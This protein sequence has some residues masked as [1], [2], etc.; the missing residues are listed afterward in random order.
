MKPVALNSLEEKVY[1]GSVT[2]DW[3]NAFL[4][5]AVTGQEVAIAPLS[6]NKLSELNAGRVGI[7]LLFAK[8]GADSIAANL[9]VYVSDS[10]YH[11]SSQGQPSF[12]NFTGLFLFFDLAQNFKHGVRVINGVPMGKVASVSS[13]AYQGG[14]DRDEGNCRTHFASM[15]NDCI[16]GF[17]DCRLTS[18]PMTIMAYEECG[19]GGFGG[20][21]GGGSSTTGSTSGGTGNGGTPTFFIPDPNLPSFLHAFYWIPLNLWSAQNVVMPPGYD[22]GLVEK[23]QKI[24]EAN[25]GLYPPQFE[26][27]MGH[28]DAVLPFYNF[29]YA[30]GISN[31]EGTLFGEMMNLAVKLRL[32]SAQ[33]AWF[34]SHTSEMAAATSFAAAH[35]YDASASVAV[36][37]LTDLKIA[38]AFPINV[39]SAAYQQVISQYASEGEGIDPFAFANACA[40]EYAI[41]KH[42]HSGWDH[43]RLVYEAIKKVT[44]EEIHLALDGIGLI[45]GI[46][47]VADVTSGLIYYM[48]GNWQDGTLSVTVASIPVAGWFYTTSKYA[49][50]VVTG[51]GGTTS[52]IFKNDNGIVRF[53]NSASACRIQLRNVLGTPAN[54]VAHHIMPLEHDTKLIVQ[55]AA[56]A[57]D[58]TPFHV[59]Q[60]GNG[61]SIYKA[62]HSGSHYNYN[63]QMGQKL[64]ALNTETLNMTNEQAKDVLNR[65]IDKVRQTIDTNS[66]TPI[67]EL[68]LPSIFPL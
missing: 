11:L 12:N 39:S 43:Y 31:G 14:E 36:R 57:A 28:P 41:L 37:L 19:P 21:G 24:R 26:Y 2:P 17:S 55:R 29:I 16:P 3:A 10:A 51:V 48:E 33:V 59:N 5:T 53:Y 44:L 30:A 67:N 23:L 6:G 47:E 54:W 61:I 63:L 42:Q 46:G 25:G 32:T 9:L 1:L 18:A 34:T 13:A 15:L 8:V 40:V 65:Y 49:K 45:P 58:Q 27:F 52:L 64:D 68:T 22:L 4:G 20:G 66:S 56:K 38:N 7:K 62:L 35:N 50:R 60:P